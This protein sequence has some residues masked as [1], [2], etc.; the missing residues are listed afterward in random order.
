MRSRAAE[1]AAA[2]YCGGF[3]VCVIRQEIGGVRGN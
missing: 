3:F 2:E 1:K